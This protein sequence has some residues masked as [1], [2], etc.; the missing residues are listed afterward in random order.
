MARLILTSLLITI[1]VYSNAQFKQV[2]PQN[3][4]SLQGTIITPSGKLK[5]VS[6]DQNAV[7]Y[8]SVDASN[9]PKL[10]VQLRVLA[11]AKDNQPIYIESRSPVLGAM[12]RQ[13]G[14]SFLKECSKVL[15]V[16]NTDK[17]MVIKK[18]TTD[19]QG[20]LHI[21][22][23]QEYNGVKVYGGEVILHGYKYGQW[24]LTGRSFPTADIN[25]IPA[26]TM[27][28]ARQGAIEN[29]GSI[30]MSTDEEIR[31]FAGK[32]L[33][34]LVIYH[35]QGTPGLAYHFT[36]HKNLMES[37][38][39]FVD[40]QDG[41][42]MKK[43]KSSCHLHDHG[44]EGSVDHASLVMDGPAFAMNE[45]DGNGVSRDI[46]TY[47][48]G[49][50][51]Y[52]IDGS[53]DMFNLSA[54]NLPNE[55][56]GAIWTLDGQRSP[57]DNSFTYTHNTDGNND[58][59]ND[60]AVS[61][62][63]NAGVAYEYFKD[64]HSRNAINGSGGTV[65]SFINVNDPNS[66][67]SMGN[68][69]WS[70]SAMFYGNGDNAFHA[71]PRGL[72][73]A[74][75][76]MSHGVIQSTANLQ[77]YGESGAMN[78]SFAD[79][80][81]AM[82]D[83]NDWKIGEDVVKTSFFP[84]GALRDLE[85]P[86]QGLP[87][88]DFGRGWQPQTVSQMYTGSEDNGGVH[89]NSGI[90]NHAFYLLA[91]SIGKE[92]AEKIY[93]RALT[94]Y[95]TMSSQFVDLRIAVEKSAQ[96][97]YGNTE[98]Q[99]VQSAF[100]DVG[101]GAGPG[102]NYQDD[103]VVNPGDDLIIHTDQNR[104]DLIIVDNQ[105]NLIANPLTDRNPVSRASVTDDGSEIVFVADDGHIYYYL[106]DYSTGNA[107]ETRLSEVGEWRNVVISKDGNR[108]A[109]LSDNYNSS[110]YVYDLVTGADFEFEL[111]NPTTADGIATGEVLYA[112]ALEFGFS[113]EKVMYDAANE[114]TGSNGQSIEYWDIG[115]LEVWN[116]SADT[117]ALGNIE[118]LFSQLPEGVSI[119]NPTF[120]KNSPY[121]IALDYISEDEYAVLGVNIETGDVGLLFENQGLGYPS[122]SRAD[123]K[124]LF[125]APWSGGIDIGVLDVQS[126]KI[127]AVQGS[128]VFF[129]EE[130]R[131]GV[132]Y[133]N[134]QRPVAVTDVDASTG[135][136]II[137]PNP[138]EGNL[139]VTINGELHGSLR[140]SLV[141]VDGKLI[142][143]KILDEHSTGNVNFDLSDHPSGVY[144]VRVVAQGKST[145]AKVVRIKN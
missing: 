78:E 123:D 75:H 2:E 145:V 137:Y 79:I 66:G 80:F 68:A 102:G 90:C 74:G 98:V 121:I 125:D 33:S 118:K 1:G 104:N 5:A 67:G 8:F 15:K 92:K 6:I 27:S 57:A 94:Q 101:I 132:W 42:I 22:L 91:T 34:E 11:R 103:V 72:D 46:N 44:L 133:A 93:Y 85:D 109:A 35:D 45:T 116:N 48:V 7:Q 26:I 106:I 49:G 141:N 81:G 83:R 41:N 124:L 105:L 51:F 76:E 62:H 115:L 32:D 50:T 117:W 60:L 25:V 138:T 97:L 59:W 129:K 64:V 139:D 10:D 65:V 36:I 20:I 63:Y 39:Y 19:D 31:N 119:G 29:I 73:V 113:G 18:E 9:L 84:S 114:I 134:G 108:L 135:K 122:Y 69:F 111:Y 55:P 37:W 30:S 100:S 21:R 70:G 71:L 99:A 47:D 144:Y 54:S 110:I 86:N 12:S 28:S 3:Q 77:Y 43:F 23:T 112:D 89:I 143:E 95:L 13:G 16:N 52:L 17:E 120:S 131:W 96:D 128:E 38:E 136:L 24:T 127:T 40:A 88:N 82:M 130:A 4:R 107:N 142:E 56:V 126:D 140:L 53:R 87:A 14:I 58:G 61:A